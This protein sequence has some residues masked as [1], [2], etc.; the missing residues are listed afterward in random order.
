MARGAGVE[1]DGSRR[2]TLEGGRVEVGE[3]HAAPKLRNDGAKQQIG[4][5]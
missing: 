4:E 3:C 5:R 2:G 1:V